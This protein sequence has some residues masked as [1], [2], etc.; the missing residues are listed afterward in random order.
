MSTWLRIAAALAVIIALAAT[1]VCHAEVPRTISY[2]M[3]LTDD[4]GVPLADQAVTLEFSIFD[5]VE[6]G[7]PLW[8]ELH[9]ETTNSIGV[10]SVV[11]GETTPLALEFNRPLWL[12]VDVDGV[13]LEPRREL[14]SSPYALHAADSDLLGSLPAHYY[15]FGEDLFVPGTINN[16]SNPVDWSNLKSVPDG[17]ADGTD[18][19]GTGVGGSGTPGRIAKFAGASTLDDSAIEETSGRVSIAW[20]GSGPALSI[21]GLGVRQLDDAVLDISHDATSEYTYALLNMDIAADDEFGDY[22]HCESWDSAGSSVTTEFSVSNGGDV[23]TWGGLEVRSGG[24]HEW[25]VEARNAFPS[26]DAHTI[27]AV[28][29]GTGPYDAAAVYGECVPQDFYGLGGKFIGGYIGVEGTVEPTGDAS[30]CGVVGGSHGGSGRNSGLVGQASGAG[31]NYGVYGLASGTGTSYGVYGETSGGATRYAGYFQGD[32]RVTGTFYN[33]AP[34]LEVD[35]PGDPE[36]SYLRHALIAS[37]EMKT[38]YDGV[39]A[40]DPDGSAWIDLPDWFESLNGDFRYQL[41]PIGAAA[42][43]LHI[44]ETISGDRFRIAG[45]Q[46]NMEV[47]WQVTGVRRDAAARQRPLTVEASK[48]PEDRGK[49]LTP[50]AFGAPVTEAIGRRPDERK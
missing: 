49:Y 25:S 40:L 19:V 37:S 21:G 12:Q 24:K 27:H 35:H 4:L 42:P 43:E 29:D 36:N 23:V 26:V 5:S 41:T 13:P 17:F 16:P 38:V 44:A 45:G 3:M 28:Y 8:G 20:P 33:S 2:Q 18:D 6:E 31:D 47:C 7:T 22:I 34:T 50:E 30:Y 10:V 48:R 9:N 11:L 14:T 39:V 15:V 46:P 32:A 1:A